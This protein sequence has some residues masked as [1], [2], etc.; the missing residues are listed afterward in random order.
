MIKVKMKL[1]Y[2]T[3]EKPGEYELCLIKTNDGEIHIAKHEWDMFHVNAML[4]F[5]SSE[6]NYWIPLDN[7]EDELDR[8]EEVGK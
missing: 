6:I 7:I 1:D 8:L 3:E 4:C 5:P 2:S